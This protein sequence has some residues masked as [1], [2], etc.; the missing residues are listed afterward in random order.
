MCGIVGLFLKNPALEGQLGAMFTP[1]LVE[2]TD[3]GPDSAGIAIYHDLP[4]EGFTKLTAFHPEPDFAWETVC[5]AV[6]T[7]FGAKV[8]HEKNNSH[9]VIVTDAPAR[10][11]A[12]LIA[13]ADPKV[14]IMSV[15]T[16]IE[17]YKEMGLPGEVARQFKLER[18]GGS[19]AVGHTRMATESAVTTAGSHPFSTGHDLC[20]VHNGSLSNHNR[21][22]E[23]LRDHEGLEFATE[24]DTEV[25]AAYIANRLEKGRS[26]HDA[27]EDCL[28]DLDGFYTFVAGTKDGFAV[29]RDPIACKPA[30]LAETPDYVAFGSEYRALVGLPGIDRAKVWEP[31]PAV[32]YSWGGRA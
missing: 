25:A 8:A 30:V 7:E 1:M 11:A 9:T 10:A 19:H 4:P 32:V 13:N 14:Q 27:L 15:G 24:N 2:M 29:L 20:L 22:R 3:R 5:D 12:R 18:M 31:E 6:G 28:E 23:R 26:L 21:L 17:I 16:A